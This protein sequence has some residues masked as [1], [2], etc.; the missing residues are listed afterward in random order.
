MTRTARKG[1]RRSRDEISQDPTITMCI[2][3]KA[4][5]SARIEE[6]AHAAGLT[7]SEYLV[8]KALQ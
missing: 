2:S 3:M 1:P 5:E 4:S 6:L 7:R 8:K